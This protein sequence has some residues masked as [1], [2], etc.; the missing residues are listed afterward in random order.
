MRLPKIRVPTVFSTS[1]L[2]AMMTSSSPEIVTSRGLD[3]K[4]GTADD[5][6]VFFFPNVAPDAGASAP[7][8]AWFTFFGQF[9]DH[10]LDLVTR[11]NNGTIFVP[12]QPDDPLFIPGSPTNL[13][14]ETRATMH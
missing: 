5:T 3:G 10:G 11:G 9:F 13:M 8:D 14:V 2:R 7:F 1:A 6:A 12:L 4:F